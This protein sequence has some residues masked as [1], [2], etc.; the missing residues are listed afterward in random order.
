MPVAEVNG[1][2]LNYMQV[3]SQDQ[4]AREDLVMVHGLATNLA[5]W[6]L[7]YVPVFSRRYRVTLFDL[8]GH[9]RSEMPRDGYTPRELATDLQMLL[10]H[11]EI[12]CAHFVAHSFGGV[13]ALRMASLDPSLVKSLVLADSHISAVR[14]THDNTD[15]EHGDEIQEILNRYDI[16]L[17]TRHPYFGY[18]LLTEIAQLQL[19]NV[20]I[21]LPLLDL[22]RPLIASHGS[23]TA[24]R[25]L[26]LME[27]TEAEREL[28]GYDG[29]SMEKLRALSFPILAIYGD[30]SQAKMT[31]EQLLDVWPHAE[32]RRVLD[33]GHF[34]PTAIPDELITSC[35]RFWDGEFADGRRHRVGETRK[36][37]FRS[38]RVY[39]RDGAWYCTTREIPALGPFSQAWEAEQS[40]ASH[41]EQQ[42]VS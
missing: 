12:E 22:V 30:R 9:G 18:K 17:D 36:S 37:H 10:C 28:M 4:D 16:S 19:K 24:M 1:V 23:Q 31:G 29:L 3:E 32:F 40:L 7:H 8:R 13:V 14:S 27:T 2:R 41:L 20:E 11:L 15:W 42:L 38:D 26:K 35:H 6:Y 39:Q 21:P 25:W 5:F 34:F 33:A